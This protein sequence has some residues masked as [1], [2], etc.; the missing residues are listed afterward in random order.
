MFEELEEMGVSVWEE[1][2]YEKWFACYD[3]EAYQQDFREG[4]D[5]VEEIESEKGTS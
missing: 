4:T 3:F 2:K 5:Q 1:D